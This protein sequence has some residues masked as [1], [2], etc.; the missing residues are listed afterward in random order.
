MQITKEM[1]RAGRSEKGGWKREQLRLLGLDVDKW[2]PKGKSLITGWQ[3]SI[4]GHEVS[5]AT[6][7]EFAGIGATPWELKLQPD[8]VAPPK[9]H[10]RVAQLISEGKPLSEIEYPD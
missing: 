6:A 2:W 9:H 1:I 7:V 8:T 4:I 3:D 5:E 10:S